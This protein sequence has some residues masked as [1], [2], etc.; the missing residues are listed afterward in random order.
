MR[1]E[2]ILSSDEDKSDILYLFSKLR[3]YVSYQRN[4][5]EELS[6]EALPLQSRFKCML[7]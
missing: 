3:N 6:T 7:N 5:T 1:N 2:N 4:F